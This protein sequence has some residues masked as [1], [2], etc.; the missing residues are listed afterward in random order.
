ML[1]R[2][3]KR[4]EICPLKGIIEHYKTELGLNVLKWKTWDQSIN[5]LLPELLL[6][7]TVFCCLVAGLIAFCVWKDYAHKLFAF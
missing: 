5:Q 2:G 4:F 3:F 1:S 6:F 7:Q